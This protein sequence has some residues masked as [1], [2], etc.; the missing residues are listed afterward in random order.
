MN[1]AEGLCPS[2]AEK[3]KDLPGNLPRGI[4]RAPPCRLEAYCEGPTLVSSATGLETAH[5]KTNPRHPR[6]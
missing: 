1:K 5:G 2:G 4:R 3:K 6:P